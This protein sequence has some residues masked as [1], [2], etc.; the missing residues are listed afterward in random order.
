VRGKK[1]SQKSWVFFKDLLSSIDYEKAFLFNMS[2]CSFRSVSGINYLKDFS[3]NFILPLSGVNKI[4]LANHVYCSTS[5]TKSLLAIL[6]LFVSYIL[7]R[8]FAV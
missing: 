1:I 3:I 2:V 6:S 5:E 4:H 7:T 8:H